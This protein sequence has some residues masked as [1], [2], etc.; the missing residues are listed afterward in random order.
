MLDGSVFPHLSLSTQ[1][2]IR[3]AYGLLVA[4][5]LVQ[6][7]PQARRFFVSERW[8]GYAQQ[9]RGVDWVQNPAALPVV[10]ALWFGSALA[11]V[12]GRW[13]VPAALINVLLCRYF[14]IQMRWRGVLR[15]MGAPGFIA[16]WLA[17]AVLLIEYTRYYA[18]QLHELALLVLQVDFALIMLSAGVYKFSAGYRANNGMELGMANPEW[19]YWWRFWSRQRPDAWWFRV[20]NELAWS[21]EVIA[22]ILMLFPPTR[23]VGG[24]LILV[25]FIFIASQ[26]RLGFLCEMVMVCCLI[27]V[28]PGSS[29]DAALAALG[30][31]AEPA[32]TAFAPSFANL[33]LAAALWV[34]LAA[35]PFAHVGLAINLYARKRFPGM[36]QRILEIYT[37]TFGIIVWRVFSADH[38]NFLIEIDECRPDGSRRRIST[39]GEGLRFGHVAESITVTTLFTTLK[40]YPSNS[41]LFTDRL[42]RYARTLPRLTGSTLEFRY[43]AVVKREDRF[44]FV[45]GATY[46]VDVTNNTVDER[47]IDPSISVRA[48]VA[49][50]PVHEAARPGTYAPAR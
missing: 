1:S 10:L 40:Y 7:L 46:T 6:A 4:A 32:V 38:T 34:Y 42:L 18:P 30:V 35:L 31:P 20:F 17:L 28:Y 3:T 29:V 21:T 44:D 33:L 13:T 48:P 5:T 22:A 11:L 12:A 2:F 43:V 49:E 39:W 36:L 9:G 15:G 23:L 45:V 8:G 47:V 19:G 25:T 50:S 27:Y 14:F 37:N 24:M 26:I 16:N 41:A